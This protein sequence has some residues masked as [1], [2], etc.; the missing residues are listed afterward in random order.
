MEKVERIDK[1]RL[2]RIGYESFKLAH[3]DAGL[4]VFDALPDFE[5]EAWR[6]S[7]HA[8][9]EDVLKRIRGR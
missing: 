7:A 3:E 6:I 4:P 8:I 9:A 2:A 1:Y 5:K